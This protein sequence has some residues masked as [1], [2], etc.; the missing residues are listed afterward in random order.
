MA[1]MR[2]G[3]VV[4]VDSNDRTHGRWSG[5]QRSALLMS[6]QTTNVTMLP[7]RSSTDDKLL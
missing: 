1:E 2:L 3:R 7:T 5:V 6:L 4:A